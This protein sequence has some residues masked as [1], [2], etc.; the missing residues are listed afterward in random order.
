[1]RLF[2]GIAVVVLLLAG[3]AASHA[4]VQ[5][6][7][8][9]RRNLYMVYEPLI[10]TVTITNLSGKDLHLAD[11]PRHKW[12]SLQVK[13]KGDRPLTPAGGGYANE[14][15][16]IPAG[17]K[18]RRSL[19]VTP[20][21][22]INEFGAYR[23]RAVV[24]VPEFENYFASPPLTFEITE[25]REL[26]SQT[27]GVPPDA[28]LEGKRRKYTLLSHRLPNSTMLYVRVEDPDRG[29][30]YCTTQLGRF[31][32]YGNPDV[33]IDRN[34]HIHILQNLS[35][36]EFLY[37]EFNLDGK[38]QRQQAYQD[39]GNRPVLARNT[40]GAVTILGGTPFDPK[41]TPPEQMLPGLGEK[42]V[43][44]PGPNA[45]PTPPKDEV[46][47]ENLLSR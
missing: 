11:S 38:V 43:P 25:G 22:P 37:S 21:F 28:G 20:A 3:V 24:Y 13:S 12:F 45:T 19:N 39:W 31:L 1:M 9:L 16:T 29:I 23:I 10:C 40:D 8:S 15:V 41:A 36:K 34:N 27:V 30:V 44:L 7:I 47:P 42:P 33:L 2:P 4:Q 5:V 6:D 32:S 26:W 18:L 17:Q 35:P 14:P 46:R